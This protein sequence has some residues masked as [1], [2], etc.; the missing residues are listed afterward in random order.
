VQVAAC[1]AGNSADAI[2]NADSFFIFLPFC[3]IKTKTTK[4]LV[5]GKLEKSI[6]ERPGRPLGG[7]CYIT[8]RF[9]TGATMLSGQVTLAQHAPQVRITMRFSHRTDWDFLSPEPTIPCGFVV[10]IKYDEFKNN[11]ILQMRYFYI[12]GLVGALVFGAYLAGRANGAARVRAEYANAALRAQTQSIKQQ[13][14]INAEVFNTN[15]GDIR[16]VLR[17]KYTIAE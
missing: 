11:R 16:R 14:K 6:S 8:D 7:P 9:P 4:R 17:E 13:E 5:V 15:L 12:F 3:C 10:S 2:K 1:A